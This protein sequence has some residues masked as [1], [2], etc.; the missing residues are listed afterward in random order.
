M[1]RTVFCLSAV[2]VILV[3]GAVFS[4]EGMWTFDNPPLKMLQESYGFT[5]APE[6]LE[7]VRLSCVRFMDGGSGAFVSP[8]GLVVTNHHVAMGQLQ[9]MSTAENNYVETGFFAASS[10]EEMPCPDLEVNVLVSMDDVTERVLSAVKPGL[11]DAEALKARKAAVARIEKESLDKT[12]L[13]SQVVSLYHGGEYWLYCYAKYTDVRLVMAPERAIAFFGG[14]DDNFTY[15]R[16]DLDMA[17]FRVY[18]NGKPL[19]NGHHLKWNARGAG[20]G[21][22]VFVPGHPGSTNRLF[23]VDDL[24]YQRDVEY[25]MML[26][27]TESRLDMLR[28]YSARGPEQARRALRSVFS[29]ENGKKVI[30]GEYTGLLDADVMRQKMDEEAEFRKQV[31]S[32]KEWKSEYGKAWDVISHALDRQKSRAKKSFYRKIFGSRLADIARDILNYVDEIPKPD[33]E[34]LKGYHDSQIDGLLFRLFSRAPIYGDTELANA[35]G[36]MNLSIAELGPTDA[37]VLAAL[38]GMTPEE[39]LSPVIEKTKLGDVAFRRQLIEGG[40]TVV[41]TCGDPMLAFMRK[42]MPITRGD[43]EW[44]Q[45]N[46]ESATT[47]ARGKI[48]Q[49]RFA[50]Y[51]KTVP[52][53]ATFTLRLSYG[54]MA[55]YPMNGTRAP[56]KTTLYGLYDRA[57]SFEGKGDFGLPQRYWERKN[58]LDLS[59]PVNFVCSCDII[60]G[61]S[62]SPVIDR[63][64]ELVGLVFD[65]NIESLVG[66]FLYDGETNRTV[67]VHSAYVIEALRKLYDAGSLADEIEGGI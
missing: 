24:K 38:G 32:K 48:A 36:S 60:G 2:L 21:E 40:K 10:G 45:K 66:R 59:I 3:P 47:A 5:P 65:G 54:T 13:K 23:T 34:R 20:E 19:Q 37:Y 8:N 67:A 11:S 51:G 63:N 33:A 62:G 35:V 49:A 12:G 1:K 50:I 26:R 64:G 55:G 16:H 17:F 18:E 42:L 7:H 43:R 29:L 28:K 27:Q 52:P 25:P 46:V 44:Y 22:L 61:N 41:D 4:E 6:W 53:D 56:Y 15:P 9:K 14:D 39:V 58:V 57:L 30:R 31:D